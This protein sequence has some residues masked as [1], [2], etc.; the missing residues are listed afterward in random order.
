MVH[1]G[2]YS[3]VKVDVNLNY[4]QKFSLCPT[5]NMICVHYKDNALKITY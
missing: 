5:E 1:A 3:R 4:T 2:E